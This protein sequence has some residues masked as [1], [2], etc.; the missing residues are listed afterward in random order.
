[1]GVS[2]MGDRAMREA[3]EACNDLPEEAQ[4]NERLN[5]YK[6][7]DYPGVDHPV[8]DLYECF[9]EGAQWQ[10]AREQDGDYWEGYE[11]GIKAARAQV[12]EGLREKLFQGWPGCSNHGCIVTGPKSGIGTNGFCQCVSNASRGE[13][14]MLQAR[15]KTLLLEPANEPPEVE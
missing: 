6:Y 9:C 3:F 13:L 1:M 12:P 5:A 11:E 4:F 2:E 8:N 14:Q 10:D 15:L 7:R